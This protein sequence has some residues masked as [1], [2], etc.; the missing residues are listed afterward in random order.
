[1]PAGSAALVQQPAQPKKIEPGNR[2]RRNGVPVVWWVTGGVVILAVIIFLLLP[3]G[4]KT[5]TEAVTLLDKDSAA[6]IRALETLAKADNDS[7]HLMLGRIYAGQDNTDLAES[8]LEP[9]TDSHHPDT[10]ACMVLSRMYAAHNSVES[11]KK[12]LT[13]ALKS[14]QAGDTAAF[15]M[16]A[17]LYWRVSQRVIDPDL[18]QYDAMLI[19]GQYWTQQNFSAA[20]FRDGTPIQKATSLEEWRYA[21]GQQIPAWCYYAFDDDDS[22]YGKLYNCWVIYNQQDIAP[23]GWHVSNVGDWTTLD[24]AVNSTNRVSIMGDLGGYFDTDEPNGFV[25]LNASSEW[26][27]ATATTPRIYYITSSERMLFD[28]D[29]TR[30]YDGCSIRLV[31]DN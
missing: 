31:Q 29:L 30:Q 19:N 22:A 26:W 28:G 17:D 13:Y 20:S 15:S 11:K 23:P 16:L 4:A 24:N 12:A 2:Q 14:Y 5:Y 1:M 10:A 18:R 6:G 21:C 27:C 8:H 25:A 9:L 3:G 7:A